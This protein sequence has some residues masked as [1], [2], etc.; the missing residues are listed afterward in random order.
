MTGILNI[1]LAIVALMLINLCM[2]AGMPVVSAAETPQADGGTLTQPDVPALENVKPIDKVEVALFSS[3]VLEGWEEKSFKGKTDYQLKIDDTQ[4]AVLHARSEGSASAIGKRI[5]INLTKTPYI[6]WLWKIDNRLEDINETKK[7]GDDFAARIYLVKT[8]GIFGRKSKAVNYVWSSNQPAGST[9]NNA[10]Q[11]RNSKMLAVRGVESNT[12]QWVAE[13]RNV[14][15]DFARMF[16][17][18]I[19]T[20]DLVVIMSDTDN[21][22]LSVSASYG[23]IYFSSE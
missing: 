8:D 14:A 20:I 6:N 7:S 13:K 3:G 2:L 12:G 11:P 22:E 1:N 21:A 10:Y 4:G 23:D 9:W 16:G 17:Q 19:S 15:M 18:S 5:K